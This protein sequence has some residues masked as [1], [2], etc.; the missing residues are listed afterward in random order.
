MAFNV[1]NF[2][3]NEDD[4][5]IAN[6][7][8]AEIINTADW[9]KAKAA[10]VAR[11][12]QR[13]DFGKGP[14]VVLLP[15]V[16]S[17]IALE[18]I[19]QALDNQGA[20]YTTVVLVDVDPTRPDPKPDQRGIKVGLLS[21]LPLQ[22]EPRSVPVDLVAEP[23]CNRD[24]GSH[25][26]TRDLLA[27]DLA[28]PDGLTLSLIG[29]HLPSGGNPR[30]CREIGAKTISALAAAMP[31]GSFALLGVDAT[32]I[33]AAGGAS[34]GQGLS[35]WLVRLSR[36]VR[37]WP[38]GAR[39]GVVG[40]LIPSTME[41]PRPHAIGGFVV[42]DCAVYFTPLAASSMIFATACGWET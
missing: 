41:S 35:M 8:N 11:V 27:A 36:V 6:G 22:G 15:E 28:L 1:E 25:G 13:F 20:A 24:D 2:F 9:V 32:G 4:P 38:R 42:S 23:Q 12:I 26:T 10:S 7:D 39:Y 16:E 34:Q 30:I 31:A 33:A 17:K 21:K 18:A 29:A 5:R 40:I 37:A 14:D 3:D 19:K